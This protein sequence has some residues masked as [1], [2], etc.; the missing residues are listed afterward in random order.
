MKYYI[1]HIEGK[2]IGCTKRLEQRVRE[3][4]YDTYTILEEHDDI[5][6]AGIRETE[7]QIQYGYGRDSNVM[8]HQVDLVSNGKRVGNVW[9]KIQG[10]KNVE[11]GEWKKVCVLGG[12]TQGTRNVESGHIQNIQKI[13]SKIG[14]NKENR[15]KASISQKKTI[16]EKGLNIGEKN[17]RAKLTLDKVNQIRELWNGPIKYSKAALGRMFGVSESMIRY[18]VTG[19]SWVQL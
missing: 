12:K 16:K 2:K 9:G 17:P 18:I 15:L 1:Y 4:G 3:Q 7:L 13:G 5:V 11:N 14:N 19:K 6:T 8:Y 10:R